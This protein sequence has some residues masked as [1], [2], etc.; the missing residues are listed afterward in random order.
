MN[1]PQN[2]GLMPTASHV[3][4]GLGNPTPPPLF[5]GLPVGQL[6]TTV[7]ITR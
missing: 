5:N 3:Y 2:P 7:D 4:N 6:V 1:Q